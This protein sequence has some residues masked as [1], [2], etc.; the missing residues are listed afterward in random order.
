[1]STIGTVEDEL[2]AT[3]SAVAER[4]RVDDAVAAASVDTSRASRGTG[5]TRCLVGRPR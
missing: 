4:T 5:D 1:M 2:A 3:L